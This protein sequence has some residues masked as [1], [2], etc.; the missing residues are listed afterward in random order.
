[1]LQDRAGLSSPD[2][3][4][5]NEVVELTTTTDGTYEYR[6][7]IGRTPKRRGI[8]LYKPFC[9]TITYQYPKSRVCVEI[10]LDWS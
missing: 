9:L 6:R 7:K 8:E 10:L 2:P 5:M 1:M 4:V 3:L